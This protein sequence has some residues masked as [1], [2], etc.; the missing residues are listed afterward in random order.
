MLT[1]M[2]AWVEQGK[3]PDSVVATARD[4][5]QCRAERRSA[6]GLG[7]GTY[8]AVMRVPESGALQERRRERRE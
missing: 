4:S 8:T 2:I 1:P 5:E 6:R 3:A 7:R